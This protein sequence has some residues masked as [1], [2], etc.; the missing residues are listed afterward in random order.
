MTVR[1]EG[2]SACVQRCHGADDAA[3]GRSAAD[4]ARENAMLREEVRVARRASDITAQL[5]VEQFVKIEEILIRLE[6]QAQSEQELGCRLAEKLRESE[7]RERELARDRERLEQMQAVAIN[8]MEDISAARVAAEA[9]ARAKTEFL[10]NMSHEIRTPMTAIL[11]YVELLAE[12]CPST[13]PYGTGERREHLAT[14]AR[15]ADHLL[16]IINGILDL[17]KIEAGR[18]ELEQTVFAPLQLVDDVQALMRLRAAQAGLEFQVEFGGAVPVAITS[19][20]MRV[21]QVLINLV[22]NAIKFTSSGSVRL[23]VRYLAPGAPDAGDLAEP[24][25]RFDVV[26]TGLG[27]T[28]EQMARLFQPFSQAD[29][30]TT[31]R[32]GGTGLGL[33][34]SKRLAKLLG[35]DIAVESAPG[36][37]TTFAFTIPAVSAAG[38]ALVTAPPPSALPPEEAARGDGDE[39]SL[40]DCRVL[41][42]EDGPDNQRLVSAVLGK[43]GAIV[44]LAENGQAAVEMALSA[45]DAGRPFDVILMDMQM[46]VLDGYEATRRLRQAGFTTPVIALTAHAMERDR[47]RCLAAGCDDYATKPISRLV[48]LQT[49]ARRLAALTQSSVGQ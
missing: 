13:C 18:L 21:K 46:P 27:M 15:N 2:L 36:R 17:S 35:G 24:V 3:A 32:F 9:A 42:V 26:D 22:G 49:I 48:L 33:A 25:L 30:S 38:A 8:M 7:V 6:Q 47:E 40:R 41:L 4:L 37:G 44:E 29:S 28:D 5:V 14:I 20:A 19:D 31:R 16:D 10:A 11:G 34:I 45:R 43:A 1:A 23:I 39:P 12:S